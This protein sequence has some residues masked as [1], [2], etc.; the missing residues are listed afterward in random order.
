MLRR[1]EAVWP[2]SIVHHFLSLLCSLSF[3]L[4]RTV[5]KFVSFALLDARTIFFLLTEPAVGLGDGRRECEW[6]TKCVCR[7]GKRER[8]SLRMYYNIYVVGVVPVYGWRRHDRNVEKFDSVNL[9]LFEIHH[10]RSS[11][12]KSSTINKRND[13]SNKL[14]KK[15]TK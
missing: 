2:L 11:K 12:S 14:N 4:R 15:K 7:G 6:W 1:S 10:N 13:S 9:W 3:T 5:P 8:E